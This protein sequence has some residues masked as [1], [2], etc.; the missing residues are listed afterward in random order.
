MKLRRLV[1]AAGDGYLYTIEYIELFGR[2]Q[3]KTE[4]VREPSHLTKMR[5]QD[6]TNQHE[7][8]VETEYK[9]VSREEF[10]QIIS[11]H[12]KKNVIIRR[13]IA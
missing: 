7:L 5:M 1:D 13:K 12:K 4:T 2:G 11:E 10:N 8:L 6:Q 9:Q 3:T